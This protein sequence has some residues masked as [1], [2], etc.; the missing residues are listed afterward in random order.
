MITCF[1]LTL[2]EEDRNLQYRYQTPR[3]RK[4]PFKCGF[5]A[6][7]CKHISTDLS[8]LFSKIQFILKDGLTRCLLSEPAAVVLMMRILKNSTNLS[9]SLDHQDVNRVT[10]VQT[11]RSLVHFVSHFVVTSQNT[12]SGLIQKLSMIYLHLNE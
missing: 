7:F 11:L 9:L 10:S 1:R 2:S 8:C 3:S 4:T 12:Y 6:V 5:I